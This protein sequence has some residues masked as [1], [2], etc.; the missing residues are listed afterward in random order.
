MTTPTHSS[1]SPL[2][3]TF[4][5]QHN[6]S[7]VSL[8]RPPPP[9]SALETV[10]QPSYDPNL[11]GRT[12]PLTGASASGGTH[13]KPPGEPTWLRIH[14]SRYVCLSICSCD[15]ISICGC[16]LWRSLGPSTLLSPASHW[17][18]HPATVTMS[19]TIKAIK[20]S[21]DCDEER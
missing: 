8:Q 13:R 19:Y 21:R 20:V 1:S 9:Y 14:H 6:H 4:Q 11:A 12:R 18:A 2:H 15:R 3:T 5:S 10:S 16:H 17:A 7:P